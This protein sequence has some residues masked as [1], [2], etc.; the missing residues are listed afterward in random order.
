MNAIKRV[1]IFGSFKGEDQNYE[2][3]SKAEEKY[4]KLGYVVVNPHKMQSN[5]RNLPEDK[6]ILHEISQLLSCDEISIMD[7]WNEAGPHIVEL[8]VAQAI[9]IKMTE[10][11]TGNE[12]N[13]EMSVKATRKSE[14]K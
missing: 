10:E 12:F 7:N 9:G 14:R 6:L 5:M 2:R 4:T 13:F 11:E 1:F 8:V 3:F